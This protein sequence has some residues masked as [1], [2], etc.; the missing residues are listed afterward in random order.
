MEPW[1]THYFKGQL[2]IDRDTQVCRYLENCLEVMG[3]HTGYD[4][5]K[6]TL[7]HQLKKYANPMKAK[8]HN[9]YYYNFIFLNVSCL[10]VLRSE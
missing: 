5:K 9:Y 8:V 4:G 1:R 2:G 10:A 3:V 7:T 6:S